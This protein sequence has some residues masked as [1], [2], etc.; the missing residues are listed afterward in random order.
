MKEHQ[1]RIFSIKI[2]E[3]DNRKKH[4]AT[5][6]FKHQSDNKKQNKKLKQKRKKLKKETFT[7][8]KNDEINSK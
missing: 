2:I 6:N 7:K 8:E 5:K 4:R 3:F 1:I